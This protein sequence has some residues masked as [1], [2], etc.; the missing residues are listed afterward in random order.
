MNRV[1]DPQLRQWWD[2]VQSTFTEIL[3]RYDPLDMGSTVGAPDD[4][5]FDEATR[6]IRSLLDLS[7]EW[8]VSQAIASRWPGADAAM[9][10]ELAAAWRP[11]PKST[12]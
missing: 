9:V 2:D 5:Y 12:S 1:S 6:T 11:P 10:D 3:Y 7:D 4:E 8:G